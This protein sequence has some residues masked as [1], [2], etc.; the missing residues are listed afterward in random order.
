MTQSGIH[1]VQKAG[2]REKISEKLYNGLIK[3]DE[4]FVSDGAKCDIGRLQMMFGPGVVSA[5]QVRGLIQIRRQSW[6]LGRLLL[7]SRGAGGGSCLFAEVL[8]VTGRLLVGR[9]VIYP[10]LR[11]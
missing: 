5:V 1:R 6:S 7:R 2:I 11:E 4:V 8:P 9:R 3:P 10:T